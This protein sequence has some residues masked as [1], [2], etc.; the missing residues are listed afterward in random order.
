VIYEPSAIAHHRRL[1]LPE[2]RAAL[3][4]AINFH[5]LKNRYLL[6]VYHQTVANA[7][8]TAVPTL[9]RDLGALGYVLLRERS[10]LAAYAWLWRH[11]REIL[12]R[13]RQIQA[14]RTRPAR[15]LDRWFL[16]EGLPVDA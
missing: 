12:A 6:R 2:R 5:S 9:L 16:Y 10:S 3:P 8:L 14:R 13:R 1:S 11:R 4:A 7:L 15:E